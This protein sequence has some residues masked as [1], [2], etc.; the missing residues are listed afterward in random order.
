MRVFFNFFFFL[1]SSFFCISNKRV[2]DGAVKL[3]FFF[4][5]PKQ[6]MI[7]VLTV[8]N[9]SQFELTF[10]ICA[11]RKFFLDGDRLFFPLLSYF[12]SIQNKVKLFKILQAFSPISTLN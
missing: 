10:V 4:A 1:F 12:K 8:P 6:F 2:D 11:I 9:I 7:S 3:S 5:L